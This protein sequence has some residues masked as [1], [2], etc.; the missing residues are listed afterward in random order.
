MKNLFTRILVLSLCCCMLSVCGYAEST[1]SKTAGPAA[2]LTIVAPKS[3]ASIPIFRMLESGCMGTD[4]SIDL[5]LYGDMQ[6]MMALASEGNYSVLIVPAHIGANLYNKGLSVQLINVFGWGGMYLSTTDSECTKWEDLRGKELYVP[7]KGSV[8]DILTQYY[9]SLHGLEIGKDVDIVY[10]SHVEIAQLLSVGTIRYAIDAQP[11]IT[12]NSK[13]I[14][15]YN[16]IS[17]FSEDWKLTQGD[18]YSL[19][20]TCT[21]ANT[22]YIAGNETLIADFNAAFAAAIAWT[23]NHPV[24]AGELAS[25][26]LNAN[27]ALI[28]E[29]MPGFCLQYQSASEAWDDIT[30]YYKVLLELKPE[31]VGGTPPDDGF[32]Y[33]CE[34]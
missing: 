13:N 2:T 27:A 9:L 17:D 32:L 22:E 19:P 14:E 24:E 30:Q 21:V 12:V 20:A 15:G 5:Q 18:A 29:A 31:S 16:V 7:A 28:A 26:Y 1:D 3:P 8:P 25:Q 4:L 23:L 10:S 11:F 33:S 34:N 6:A